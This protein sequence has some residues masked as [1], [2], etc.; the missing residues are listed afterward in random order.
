MRTETRLTRTGADGDVSMG[1][2]GSWAAGAA[3]TGAGSRTRSTAPTVE[4][5]RRQLLCTAPWAGIA[6]DRQARSSTYSRTAAVAGGR[7]V[8]QTWSPPPDAW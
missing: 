7:P 1:L 8:G 3:T 6:R 5:A 2:A 4:A